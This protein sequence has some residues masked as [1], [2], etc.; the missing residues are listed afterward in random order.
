MTTLTQRILKTMQEIEPQAGDGALVE[1]RKLR[2]A[3]KATKKAFDAAVIELADAA[4]VAL[5]HY[6]ASCG[7]TAK[8]R[9]ELVLDI[10]GRY[11]HGVAIR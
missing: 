5:H 9:Q 7:L 8:D 3:M 1:I 6:D 2:K 4:T 10:D 11:A